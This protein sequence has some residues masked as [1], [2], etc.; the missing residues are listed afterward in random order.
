MFS[1]EFI[2]KFDSRPE[3]IQFKYMKQRNREPAFQM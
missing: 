1:R 3:E 2:Y